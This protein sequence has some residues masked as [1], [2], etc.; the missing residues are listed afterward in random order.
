VNIYEVTL[1]SFRSYGN[2]YKKRENGSPMKILAKDG[3]AAVK[4]AKA[5]I[6]FAEPI[7]EGL[8]LLVTEVD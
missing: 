4:K 3:D 7:L 6:S 2:G 5:K 8:E 1:S